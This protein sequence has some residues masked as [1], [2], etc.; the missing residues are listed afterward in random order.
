MERLRFVPEYPA[1]EIDEQQR[2]APPGTDRL[3]L[4]SG[5]IRAVL[6]G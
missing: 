4:L 5:D 6:L 1:I 2:R 3:T